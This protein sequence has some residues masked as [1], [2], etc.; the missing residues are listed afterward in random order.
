MQYA[1][2][3]VG[4]RWLATDENGDSMI[5]KIEIRGAGETEWK[6]LK[7]K[8]KEKQY[9]WDSTAYQDGEYQV[10][11]TASDLPSN[12]PASALTALIESDP[13]VIDNTPPRIL[14]LKGGISGSGI[15]VKWRAKDSLNLLDKAEYSV[16]GGDW[17][18]VEPVTKLTD[19]KELEYSLTLSGLPRGEHTIAV[20]VAD[21]YDNQ[22]V[23]KTVVR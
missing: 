9:S 4:V 16:D 22:A 3:F 21:E 7:D 15:V 1:K 17:T 20:R 13:F 19:A 10:R 6:L 2:G 18:V 12:P 5:Y 23:E 8:L 14:D 11:V